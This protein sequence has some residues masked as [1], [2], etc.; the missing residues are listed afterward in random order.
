M[1]GPN[2]LPYAVTGERCFI[3]V[4]PPKRLTS[5]GLLHIPQVAQVRS[6]SGV[7]VDAGLQARDKL[8]D[9]GY[10][11]GDHVI[12]GKFAG[13]IEEWDHIIEGDASKPDEAYSW[14]KLDHEPGTAETFRCDN[15]D[16][17]RAVEPCCVL[18][19]DDLLASVELAERLRRG[20]VEYR[21]APTTDGRVQHFV[22]S[23]PGV[24]NA[25]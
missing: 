5:S 8:R 16:A 9:H 13:I 17:L 12:F 7:L 11:I 22:F 21:E 18:N 14:R 4:D 2:D 23:N 3:K 19:C 20:T 10:R 6:F 15:T 25:A 1:L 24:A